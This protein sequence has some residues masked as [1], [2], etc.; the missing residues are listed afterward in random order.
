MSPAEI[1][2]LVLKAS[3]LAIVFSLGLSAR[4]GDLISVFRRP[5]LLAR[6][7]MAMLVVMPLLTILL[8]RVMHLHHTVAVMLVAL[9]LAP[10]PPILPRK[11]AKAGGASSYAIGLLAAVALVSI[12]WIPLALEIDQR[13]FSIPLGIPAAKVATLVAT[14]VLVPLIAGAVVGRLAPGLAAR[15]GPALSKAGGLLLALA[16][17]AILISQW[18]AILALLPAAAP[19]FA[20]FVILGL[21]VGHLLGGPEPNDRSVLAIATASR[22]PGVALAIA[23]INFPGEQALAA[24]VLLF[25]LVN[26]VVSIPYVA[27]RKKAG[28][29]A[30][31]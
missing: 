2:I 24:A 12:G 31:L 9:S 22:H 11:Q 21:L 17:L 18:K 10:V 3:V 19:V 6:S 8:V 4:P 13:V 14:T 29:A 16:A 30:D 23:H 15:I 27:W 20:L 1:V 26:A 25:L 5:R 7:L 28:A